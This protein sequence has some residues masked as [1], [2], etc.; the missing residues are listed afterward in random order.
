MSTQEIA[1]IVTAVSVLTLA[2]RSLRSRN[3]GKREHFKARLEQIERSIWDL[4]FS[5]EKY[6]GIREGIRQQ[7]D[8]VNEQLMNAKAALER[9][10]AKEVRDASVT[11]NLRNLIQKYEPDCEYMRKQISALDQQIDSDENPEACTQ[12]IA[13]SRELAE[14]LKIH[15]KKLK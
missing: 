12:K 10:E 13:A 7:Y 5:R 2:L 1:S 11:E 9:E 4:E 14:M 6:K 3:I 8:R 15:I